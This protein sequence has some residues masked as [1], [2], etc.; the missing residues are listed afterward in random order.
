MGFLVRFVF[1]QNISYLGSEASGDKITEVIFNIIKM[2]MEI[3]HLPTKTIVQD[4][5]RV[6]NTC[7][8]LEFYSPSHI[9][10]M[11]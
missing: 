7:S 6:K 4:N 2:L 5:Q 1:G 8:Q 3:T 11:F 10:L 9:Y